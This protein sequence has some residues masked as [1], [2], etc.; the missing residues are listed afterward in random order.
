M[1]AV[2]TLRQLEY[3]IAVAEEEHFTRAAERLIIAQPSL[4]RTVKDLEDALR[5][6]LFVR[7]STGVTLT[8]AGRELLEGARTICGLVDRTVDSV[9]ATAAGQRG[10]LRLAYYGPSFFNNFVTREAL[11]RFRAETP[12]AE[13][14][15]LEVFSEQV[16]AA[17]REGRIDVAISRGVSPVSDIEQRLIV[18]EPLVA[19]VSDTDELATKPELRFADLDGHNLLGFRRDL[20]RAQHDRVMEL[21]RKFNVT[22]NVTRELSQLSTIAHYVSQGEGISV[23]PASS[24]I[25]RFPGVTTREFCDPEAT[26]DLFAVTRRGESSPMVLRLLE[27]LGAV[28]PPQRL[29][30]SV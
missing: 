9:R 30:R 16:I 10:H 29:A 28:S 8:D 27:L 26:L 23:V 25:C 12:D 5:V 17:L 4:S 6:D 3:F 1:N 24:G 11:D 7:E 19:M 20:T 22:L 18:T 13:V 21:A 14:S 15:A 2:I